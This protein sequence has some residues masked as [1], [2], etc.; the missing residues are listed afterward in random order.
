MDWRIATKADLP[1]IDALLRR[2]V[3]SS[4]FLLGNLRDLVLGW[5]AAY[6]AEI[7]GTADENCAT[8]AQRDVVGYLERG[9]HRLLMIAGRAFAMCGFNAQMS[10]VVQ[11]GGVYTPPGSRG[12][13]CASCRIVYYDAVCSGTGGAMKLMSRLERAILRQGTVRYQ[14]RGNFRHV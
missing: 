12:N 14:V 4:M 2:H 13:G 7:L 11:V 9:S 5:R 10:D 6:H 8:E 1:H 3:Q